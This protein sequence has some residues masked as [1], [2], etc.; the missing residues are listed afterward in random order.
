MWHDTP[1]ECKRSQEPKTIVNTTL[2]HR[3]TRPL[4]SQD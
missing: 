2:G 3:N 1:N 4:T